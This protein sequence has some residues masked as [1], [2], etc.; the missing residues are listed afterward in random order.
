MLR[1]IEFVASR[2]FG[3]GVDTFILWICSTFIFNTYRYC[4]QSITIR[5]GAVDQSPYT[6][7]IRFSTGGFLYGREA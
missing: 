1:Y 4:K 5:L 3:T 6:E 7:N 2:L